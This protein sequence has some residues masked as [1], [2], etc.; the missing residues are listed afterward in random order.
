MYHNRITTRGVGASL[1]ICRSRSPIRP[2]GSVGR[3]AGAGDG[4][5]RSLAGD[6]LRRDRW[7]R[8]RAVHRIETRRL[9]RSGGRQ[10]C[11]RRRRSVRRAGPC[12]RPRDACRANDCRTTDLRRV[13]EVGDDGRPRVG[14]VA[15]ARRRPSRRPFDSS[16]SLAVSARCRDAGGG[17]S[18][19]RTGLRIRCQQGMCR[20]IWSISLGKPINDDR[21]AIFVNGIR[22]SFPARPNRECN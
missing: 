4:A 19:P 5:S 15:P 16:G 21:N 6:R 7:R 1:A 14:P 11:A 17:S 22:V 8:P 20:E 13:S 9:R 2:E 3:A 18:R 12:R 10:K